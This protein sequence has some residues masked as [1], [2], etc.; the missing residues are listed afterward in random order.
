MS[1]GLDVFIQDLQ[2]QWREWKEKV[3][4]QTATLKDTPA[5]ITGFR[6]SFQL[7]EDTLLKDLVEWASNPFG[8]LIPVKKIEVEVRYSDGEKLDTGDRE[9]NGQLSLYFFY[10]R[11]EDDDESDESDGEGMGGRIK[12]AD[13]YVIPMVS[14]MYENPLD[15][16]PDPIALFALEFR[17]PFEP[18]TAV[19][20]GAAGLNPEFLPFVAFYTSRLQDALSS[21]SAKI[22]DKLRDTFLDATIDGATEVLYDGS[23]SGAFVERDYR[24]KR[25][26]LETF[27]T[28]Y[29][30]KYENAHVVSLT[31][32]AEPDISQSSLK[33]AAL[34]PTLKRLWF[35]YQNDLKE[36]GLRT[37]PL[38]DTMNLEHWKGVFPVHEEQKRLA[39]I[40]AGLMDHAEDFPDEA[41][42]FEVEATDVINQGFSN[43]FGFPV[44]MDEEFPALT[45][46]V[47]T[48]AHAERYNFQIKEMT[49]SA[50][51]AERQQSTAE[52]AA[53]QEKET[54]WRAMANQISMFKMLRRERMARE[55]GPANNEPPR[56]RR[57]G[58]SD[59]A[60][61]AD[62]EVRPTKRQR[63]EKE[64]AAALVAS[65]GDVEAAIKALSLM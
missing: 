57:E 17:Q 38:E 62:S 49:R 39:Q 58:P 36:L 31:F 13:D 64:I 56:K 3:R 27:P 61:S 11:A 33:Q 35:E 41:Q 52:Q 51:E 55:A 47:K 7:D 32:Y 48:I 24:G 54:R 65:R 46:G 29:D 21:V 18:D 6:P 53:L 26:D 8:G 12:R 5:F 2:A 14:L 1:A 28:S 4:S 37:R 20:L 30:A 34:L 19:L 60:E 50:A 43:L 42:E 10:A 59:D 44:N 16:Y 22:G 45:R 9:R 25:R 40:V 63:T 15:S 23:N